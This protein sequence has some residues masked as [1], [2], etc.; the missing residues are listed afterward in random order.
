MPLSQISLLHLNKGLLSRAS[1]DVDGSCSYAD[2]NVSDRFIPYRMK[3]NLQAKFEAVSKN[4][5]DF[6]ESKAQSNARPDQNDLGQPC[7]RIRLGNL[8]SEQ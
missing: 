2:S 1:S 7:E 4:Q 6:F 8:N 3:E 5:C